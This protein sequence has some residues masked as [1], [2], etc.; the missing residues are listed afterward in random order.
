MILEYTPLTPNS[1][2]L[3]MAINVDLKL[4]LPMFILE[5]VSEGFGVEFYQNILKIAK[6][7][8]GSKWEKKIQ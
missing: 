5:S 1:G 4:T 8:K 6:T 2:K 7:L 3:R